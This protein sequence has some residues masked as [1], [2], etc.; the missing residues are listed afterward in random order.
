[1]GVNFSAYM[2]SWPSSQSG[3][4]RCDLCIHNVFGSLSYLIYYMLAYIYYIPQPSI[5]YL[6]KILLSSWTSCSACIA[7][8]SRWFPTNWWSNTFVI[9]WP[10][11]SYGIACATWILKAMTKHRRMGVQEWYLRATIH[12][13]QWHR[14]DLQKKVLFATCVT[15]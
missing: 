3:L 7:S 14:L 15:I 2:W 4:F 11:A 1:M 10:M 13:A 8:G 9:Q 6:N 5:D 12:V